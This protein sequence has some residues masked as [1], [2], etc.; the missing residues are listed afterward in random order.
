MTDCRI[1]NNV[2]RQILTALYCGPPV[3]LLV[4]LLCVSGLQVKSGQDWPEE[5]EE[6]EWISASMNAPAAASHRLSY[7]RYSSNAD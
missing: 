4:S 7:V 2:C 6:K 3:N 1:H 5:N